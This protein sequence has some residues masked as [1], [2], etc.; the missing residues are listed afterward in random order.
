M[1]GGLVALWLQLHDVGDGALWSRL[2]MSDLV[3]VNLGWGLLNLLPVLP[4]DGGHIF[5]LLIEKL[6][7]KPVSARVQG[8]AAAGGAILLLS[9]MLF[10][11]WHDIAR[12]FR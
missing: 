12:M 3:F 5:F 10:V 9:L 4:L 2:L 7:G 11:T 8:Y 6:R 1:V